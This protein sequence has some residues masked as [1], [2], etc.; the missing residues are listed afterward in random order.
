ARFGLEY[1]DENGKKQTPVM[2]HRAFIGS[3]E[4]FIGLLL[5]HYAGALPFWL[6]PVQVAILNINDELKPYAAETA[7]ELKKQNIRV[8]VDARNESIGKKIREGEM[9]KIPYLLII[10]E[11][12]KASGTV[13]VRERGA[14]D[15]GQI[16]INDFMEICKKL[17]R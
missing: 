10:G 5:E 17:S 15:K 6:T 1:T 8:T 3:T 12:E 7:R 2:V 16:K 13:S 9:Q 11:K 14:G 4:R